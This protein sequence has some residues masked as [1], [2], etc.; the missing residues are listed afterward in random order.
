MFTGVISNPT[1]WQQSCNVTLW[2]SAVAFVRAYRKQAAT[3]IDMLSQHLLQ[4]TCSGLDC[5]DSSAIRCSVWSER[6]ITQ[7]VSAISGWRWRRSGALEWGAAMQR[8]SAA[9]SDWSSCVSSHSLSVWINYSFNT[10]LISSRYAK[11]LT[12]WFLGWQRVFMLMIADVISGTWN[13]KVL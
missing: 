2:T 11:L 12:R 10:F 7:E 4:T 13:H 8:I 9:T 6:V 5:S 3:H 1:W